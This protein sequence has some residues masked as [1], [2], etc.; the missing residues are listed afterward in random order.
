[1]LKGA[2]A[3][4][5]GSWLHFGSPAT[6]ALIATDGVYGISAPHTAAPSRPS[7]RAPPSL[8]R[9]RSSAAAH[10]IKATLRA[11]KSPP[12]PPSPPHP[13]LHS[14]TAPPP[15]LSA[16]PAPPHPAVV[17]SQCL[18][19]T[20]DRRHAIVGRLVKAWGVG[21]AGVHAKR[22]RVGPGSA[23]RVLRVTAGAI[24]C[25]EWYVTPSAHSL[26]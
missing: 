23:P 3:T 8:P 9:W 4:A 22:Q 5:R 17:H 14:P 20:G 16:R 25:R 18:T 10:R 6:A 7:G 15:P 21:E 26:C 1:M 12:P 13:P 11:P 2:T 19:C 24:D